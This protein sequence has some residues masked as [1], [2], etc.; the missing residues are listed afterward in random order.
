MISTHNNPITIGS[1]NI[2]YENSVK[3]APR[4][5]ITLSSQQQHRQQSI[6]INTLLFQYFQ[7]NTI[8]IDQ[9]QHQ[10]QDQD[11]D[12]NSTQVTSYAN[13]IISLEQMIQ[14]NESKITIHTVTSFLHSM[15]SQI[16]F[17]LK[18]KLAISFMEAQ[19]IMVVDGTHFFFCNYNK[20]YNIRNDKTI[21]VTDF[22]DVHNLTLPPEFITNI[23][24]PFSTYYTS[25]FYSLA[26]LILRCL[27][28]I[29]GDGNGLTQCSE[30]TQHEILQ[31]YQSQS[32]SQSQY[33]YTK[34]YVTLKHC[35]IKD[36]R[37][38]TLHIF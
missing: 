17:L 29:C 19:D 8:G 26:I 10:D 11:Q 5:T 32:Q 31:Y 21:L 2:H 16:Q 3:S 33:Q 22:Y 25:S 30:T 14:S 24:L 12:H 13:S 36:P 34:L 35:L 9:H 7:S 23:V 6:S 38:R 28:K 20:L 37:Q 18:H 4:Y 15:Y 27:N 1:L